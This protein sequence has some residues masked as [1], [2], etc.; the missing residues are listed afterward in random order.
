MKKTDNI[1]VSSV[2]RVIYFV[3]DAEISI[4]ELEN[5]ANVPLQL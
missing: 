2:V 1:F 4:L 5:I 3:S